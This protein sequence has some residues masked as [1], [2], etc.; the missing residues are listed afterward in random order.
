MKALV[1]L[2][3]ALALSGAVSAFAQSNTCDRDYKA[4]MES[5][6]SQRQGI[7][8]YPEA[9]RRFGECQDKLLAERS[10]CNLGF[11]VL[12]RNADGPSGVKWAVKRVGSKCSM[13][14]VGDSGACDTCAQQCMQDFRKA[15]AT[16]ANAETCM[17]MC[18]NKLKL[19][20]QVHR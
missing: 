6:E 12:R 11:T 7:D 4:G 13:E 1:A 5:C 8:N 19:T 14:K 3:S 18:S 17:S 10:C 9:S 20:C 16:T 2:A 15:G